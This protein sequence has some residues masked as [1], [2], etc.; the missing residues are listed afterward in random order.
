MK[1]KSLLTT[2]AGA[3]AVGLGMVSAPS[4]QQVIEQVAQNGPTVVQQQVNNQRNIR[5][6]QQQAQQRN[7]QTVRSNGMMNPYY[8]VGGG[9]LL[10]S[11]YGMSPKEYGEYL[12]RTGK[13][14]QNKR[15]RKHWAKAIS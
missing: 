6:T 4:T 9:G 12:M 10:G 8:P 7:V 1:K 11:N 13:D 5:S 15:R 3:M 14:K 2:M